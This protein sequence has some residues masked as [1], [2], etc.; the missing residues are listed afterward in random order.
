MTT[1]PAKVQDSEGSTDLM[2]GLGSEACGR[3]SKGVSDLMRGCASVGRW[4]W[5]AA[6]GAPG[7]CGGRLSGATPYGAI[8]PLSGPVRPVG[9]FSW[10]FDIGGGR[11]SKTSENG[12]QRFPRGT[13]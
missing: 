4:H 10:L 3:I 1:H 6:T 2:G 8:V 7:K 5:A 9:P 11:G 13:G 12:A